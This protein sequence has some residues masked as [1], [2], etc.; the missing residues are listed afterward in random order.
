MHC[1]AGMRDSRALSCVCVSARLFFTSPQNLRGKYEVILPKNLETV[2]KTLNFYGIELST[3]NM[4]AEL[5]PEESII[6]RNAAVS[7]PH[8]RGF[9]T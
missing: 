9:L 2:E 1:V 4:H 7:I 5:P 8:I 3:M 6:A